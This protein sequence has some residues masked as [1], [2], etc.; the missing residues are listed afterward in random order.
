MLPLFY[1]YIFT[2]GNS[3]TNQLLVNRAEYLNFKRQTLYGHMLLFD[4]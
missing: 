1:A 3:V 4:G 2:I